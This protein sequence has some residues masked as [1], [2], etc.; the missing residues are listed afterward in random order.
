MT[1]PVY[2]PPAIPLDKV[3]VEIVKKK[4]P[5]G[6]VTVVVKDLAKGEKRDPVKQ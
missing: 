4:L 5:D 6:S 3:P 2:V 1:S